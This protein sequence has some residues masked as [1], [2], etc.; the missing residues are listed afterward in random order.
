[1]RSILIPLALLLL[2]FTGCREEGDLVTTTTGS[3]PPPVVVTP[4]ITSVVVA[5]D[6]TPV[7]NASIT[8]L[9]SAATI[10][11]DGTVSIDAGQLDPNGSMI[12]ISSPGFW[13]ENRVLMP[14]PNGGDLRETFVMEP[15]V[16]A[17]EIDPSTGGTIEIAEN[18]SVTLPAN[19]IATTADGTPYSGPV[20]VY[21]NHDAPEDANEMLNSAINA[22]GMMEDG[23]TVALESY[24]MMDIALETPDG[25]PL[26]LDE[27]TKAEVRMPIAPDTEMRG[28][29]QVPFWVLDPAGFWLPAGFATLAPG[30]YVVY[31]V[32]SGTCN[33][34]IP[35]P[36][37]RLC[38]R[39][40][41]AGGFP[42]THSP[43]TVGVVEGML[44]GASRI[45]CQGEFCIDVVADLNLSLSVVDPCSGEVETILVDPIAL[46]ETR[47][48]GDIVVDLDN[49]AFFANVVDCSGAALPGGGITEIWANGY[50]GNDGQYFAPDGDG[51]TVVSLATCD[52]EVIV[53]AFT[54]DFRAASP[55]IRRPSLDNFPQDFVVC[56]D[57]SDDE[58]FTL[59][60]GDVE[61]PIT[62]L[63]PIYWPENDTFNWQVR[64]A[65]MLNG[66]EY[67][68][69][70]KFS[71]PTVG[72]YAGADAFA[73]VYRL[74]PGQDYGEGRVY[75]D[76]D[77]EIGLVGTT[78]SPEGDI[79]EGTFSARMNLQNDVAQTVEAVNVNVT[80]TFRIKL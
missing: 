67:S 50:G 33:I 45:D 70:F 38:G 63:A 56:G 11:P 28:P 69:F 1:M 60:I 68:L 47:N 54:N 41:D 31:I 36:T 25:D 20:E 48:L 53:Q 59:T 77:Q 12:T 6:G 8:G 2:V 74:M 10:N 75:V 34:D 78:V 18:F 27:S 62:E 76:P 65:G 46:N 3:I 64:A 14:G 4:T 19:T 73:A 58:F 9:G 52:D 26:L 71:E 61:V 66:E 32:S 39:F 80:A 42:L 7:N 16:K 51:Q 5:Q 29:E 55:V 21:V 49:P 15:K 30:C 79:F 24:G 44:C 35:H 72:E 43:F 37:A 23:S 40:V 17:G 22:P 57:L 13:P